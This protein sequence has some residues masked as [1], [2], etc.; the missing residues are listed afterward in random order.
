MIITKK[1]ASDNIL[2]VEE[3]F[4]APKEK[5]FKAWTTPESLK[6]WFMA[7]EG[8]IVKDAEVNLHVQGTYFIKVVF[9]GFDPT[10]I[11]GEFIKV[12]IPS[13]LEY[14]WTTPVLNGRITKVD[15][16]FLDQEQGSKIL[17]SHGEF[18]NEAEMKLH[19]DGWVGCL[20]KLHELLAVI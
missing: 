12:E 10:P 20:G 17:L 1:G 5:V 2:E 9:P 15:V 8:V 11:E 16:V 13:A 7:D 6:K 4:R 18:E 14:S 3:S 19:L